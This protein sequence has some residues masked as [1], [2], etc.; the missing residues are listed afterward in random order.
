MNTDYFTKDYMS[1]AHWSIGGGLLH[2]TTMLQLCEGITKELAGILR[3]DTLHATPAC[4]WSVDWSTQ[5]PLTTPTTYMQLLRKAAELKQPVCLSFDNPYVSK[6]LVE[7]DFG[8]FLVNELVQNNPTNRNAVVVADDRVAM[9][10]RRNFPKL[11][12]IAHMNRSVC[13][14]NEPDAAFYNHLLGFYNA[15]QLY[16]ASTRIPQLLQNLEH[17]ERCI[18]VTNDCC[19]Q[20]SRN[21]HR[22]MLLLLA[23]MRIRPYE[24]AFKVRRS[25]QM[26]ALMSVPGSPGNALSRKQIQELYAAGFRNFHV[27]AEQYRNGMTPAWVLMNLITPAATEQSNMRALVIYKAFCYLNGAQSPIASGL[28]PFTLRYPE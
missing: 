4:A 11:P 26:P 8:L 5:R 16:P 6:N 21:A 14:E 18:I 17:P 7:D 10:L 2:G 28:E 15:V 13:E 3:L 12:L 9:V 20:G 1:G 24:F 27:Q 25:E 22:D 23:Q 19:R